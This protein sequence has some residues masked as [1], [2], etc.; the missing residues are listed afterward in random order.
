MSI[1]VLQEKVKAHHIFWFQVLLKMFSVCKCTVGTV[2]L[3]LHQNTLCF[4]K[5]F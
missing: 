1:V 2:F 5:H 4:M 3:L